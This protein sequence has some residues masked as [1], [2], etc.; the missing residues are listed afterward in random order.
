M[1]K[2]VKMGETGCQTKLGGGG[3]NQTCFITC[4]VTGPPHTPHSP[5]GAQGI[6][7]N[8]FLTTSKICGIRA[9]KFTPWRKKKSEYFF[10][11]P[12][13]IFSADYFFL[14]KKIQPLKKINPHLK[15]NTG[16]T[17]MGV[18]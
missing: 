18:I 8:T 3:Q 13:I 6:A 16:P 15:K 5:K 14:A 1:R 7:H 11:V 10:L 17:A 12:N 9:K 2:K 4:A